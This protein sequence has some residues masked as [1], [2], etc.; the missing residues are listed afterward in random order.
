MKMTRRPTSRVVGGETTPFPHRRERRAAILDLSSTLSK[1][2]CQVIHHVVTIDAVARLPAG[3]SSPA[4]V[5][6]CHPTIATLRHVDS[7]EHFREAYLVPG[8]SRRMILAICTANAYALGVGD[9]L[10]RTEDFPQLAGHRMLQPAAQTTSFST[11]LAS[12]RSAHGPRITVQRQ[13]RPRAR[14]C[15]AR[16]IGQAAHLSQSSGQLGWPLVID[17][18]Q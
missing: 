10:H 17:R 18:P 13:C 6:H 5:L 11:W 4:L 2:L 12:P 1:C 14:A 9:D 16:F 7:C 3:H 8:C 15:V